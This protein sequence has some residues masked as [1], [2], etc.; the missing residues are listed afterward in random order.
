MGKKLTTKE[1]ARFFGTT[2]ATMRRWA[3][4][5][6]VPHIK[7]PGGRYI[8]DLDELQEYMKTRK[9]ELSEVLSPS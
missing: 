8:F 7:N 9:L 3:R 4:E 2:P 1:A 5:K 6:R